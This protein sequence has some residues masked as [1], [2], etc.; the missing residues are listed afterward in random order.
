MKMTSMKFRTFLKGSSILLLLMAGSVFGQTVYR[1]RMPHKHWSARLVG[2][3]GYRTAGTT[4]TGSFDTKYGTHEFLITETGPYDLQYDPDG[5]TDWTTDADWDAG[6]DGKWIIGSDMYQ[7][8]SDSILFDQYNNV[9]VPYSTDDNDAD[10]YL[11]DANNDTTLLSQESSN[12]YTYLEHYA[13]SATNL[14]GWNGHRGNIRVLGNFATL[15]HIVGDTVFAVWSDSTN[16]DCSVQVIGDMYVGPDKDG[17]GEAWFIN[18]DGDTALIDMDH[19]P[20][21]FTLQHP[22]NSYIWLAG[23]NGYRGRAYVNGNLYVMRQAYQDTLFSVITDSTNNYATVNIIGQGFIGPDNDGDGEWFFVNSDGDTALIDMD[24]NPR[25]FYIEH[26]SGRSTRLT[27][28][29]GYR[30]KVEVNGDLR[31]LQH[32]A[33]DTL[34][35]VVTDSTNNTVNLQVGGGTGIKK[36]LQIGNHLAFIT[37]ANDTFYTSAKNDST[38]F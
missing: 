26:P 1:I 7:S 15:T 9:V 24:H 18:S 20:R 5:G 34:F 23:K 30:G 2:V 33:G 10:I 11:V 19:N 22:S 12:G 16:G 17:D 38:M 6:Q 32:A 8:I 13:G 36:F 35:S 4:V 3:T 28:R 21:V 37:T 31:I 25:N 29:N 14:T 27:G